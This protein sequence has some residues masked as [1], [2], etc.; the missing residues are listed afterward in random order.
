MQTELKAGS[1]SFIES[2]VMGVAGSAPGYTIAAT[3]S[4]Q[5]EKK[6]QNLPNSTVVH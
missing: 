1:L 2:M 6:P 5:P 3:I 4:A